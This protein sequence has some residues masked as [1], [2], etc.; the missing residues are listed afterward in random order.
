ML[1]ATRPGLFNVWRA[2]SELIEP[3]GPAADDARHA[4][5]CEAVT[6]GRVP[7]DKFLHKLPDR[8]TMP[9][10]VKPLWTA[11]QVTAVAMAAVRRFASHANQ[12]EG[13]TAAQAG[14]A[15]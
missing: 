4:E 10:P 1:A 8:L 5:L 9:D 13:Q 14:G 3:A 7:A 12:V 11:E 2:F 15:R 6:H